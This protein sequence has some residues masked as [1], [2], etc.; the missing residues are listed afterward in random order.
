MDI[1]EFIKKPEVKNLSGNQFKFL[2]E[3]CSMSDE[4]GVVNNFTISGF[5]EQAKKEG[6]GHSTSRNSLAKYLK[7]FES[8]G[9]LT[10]NRYKKEI[11]FGKKKNEQ[12]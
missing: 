8:L 11:L 9:I 1:K 12:V 4:N 10:H 2:L 7:E 6:N 3:L 5:A